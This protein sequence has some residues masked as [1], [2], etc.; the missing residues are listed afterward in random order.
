MTNTT[1]AEPMEERTRSSDWYAYP[2]S[3]FYMFL[4]TLLLVR[5]YTHH[6]SVINA[7][8]QADSSCCSRLL[9]GFE[10]YWM[11]AI[12][13]GFGT[14]AM[15][16]TE[17]VGGEDSITVLYASLVSCF[18]ACLLNSYLQSRNFQDPFETTQVVFKCLSLLFSCKRR[19]TRKIC[20]LISKYPMRFAVELF[21]YLFSL[22]FCW[23]LFF[24]KANVHFDS[25]E[26][27]CFTSWD[28]VSDDNMDGGVGKLRPESEL[29][30]FGFLVYALGFYSV[31]F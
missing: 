14:L 17:F 24:S 8:D 15:T 30:V 2:F 31:S 13:F 6:I 10:T 28:S 11:A 4:A 9:Q 19:S 18:F 23:V 5:R 21:F 26:N 27:V 1:T 7:R 22:N 20:S 3:I 25:D 12:I 29:A 16:F